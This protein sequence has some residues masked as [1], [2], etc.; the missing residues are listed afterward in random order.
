MDKIKYVKNVKGRVQR[1]AQW[2]K[3][4]WYKHKDLSF[5]FPAHR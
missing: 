1:M 5:R 4:L 3:D 2:E